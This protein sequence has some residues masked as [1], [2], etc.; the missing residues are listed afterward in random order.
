MRWGIQHRTC[1]HYAASVSDSF[2][3]VRLQPFSNE[4]QTVEA[5][6]LTVTPATR[7]SQYHDFHANHVHHFH[8]TKPHT[9]LVIESRLVVATRPPPTLPLNARPAPM[10]RLN[11]ALKVDRCYDFIQASRYVDPSPD[12]WRLAVDALGDEPDLWQG[13]LRLMHFVHGHLTYQS[14]ST[15]VHT[16]MREALAQRRGVCQDFA[17]VLLGLCRTLRLP[18]LYVS[19]YLASETAS[20]THAWVEV[21]IPGTGW[22]AL[23][24]THDRPADDTYVKIGVGRDYGDVT[25]V[26]GTYKGT[27][28]RTM[29]V[30][31]KIEPR[32]SG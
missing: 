1:Y 11:D 16:H 8:I 30:E 24:P 32:E 18:A 3:E 27:T 9:E 12:V 10:S 7:V 31:V 26:K 14:N 25:P 13:A 23:D 29:T 19:G 28:D 17:H 6:A 22:Q 2:N 4:Y 15:R 21:F 5:F 20:A